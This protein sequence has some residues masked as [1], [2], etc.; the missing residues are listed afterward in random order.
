MKP[1]KIPLHIAV[2][3]NPSFFSSCLN[4]YFA[5]RTPGTSTS[6]GIPELGRHEQL[7]ARLLRRLRERG[8]VH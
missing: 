5:P 8:L 4:L 7:H 2:Y 1:V 6:L 3:G